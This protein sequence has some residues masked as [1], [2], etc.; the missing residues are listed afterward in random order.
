MDDNV[1]VLPKLGNRFAKQSK[2]KLVNDDNVDPDVKRVL[3]VS[4]P[5]DLDVIGLQHEPTKE[6][7]QS[8]KTSKDSKDTKN[9]KGTTSSMWSWVIIVLAFIVV[10]LVIA[11]A[12]YILKG[13][14]EN[15]KPQPIP[16]NVLEPMSQS[17]KGQ[18][19][20]QMPN[21]MHNQM[22]NQMPNQ[23]HN[24]MPNQ[25][26]NCPMNRPQTEQLP[27]QTKSMH[28]SQHKQPS[29]SELEET[30]KKLESI[31]ETNDEP[32]ISNTKKNLLKPR[33]IKPVKSTE[34][35]S[36][37]TDYDDSSENA[38]LDNK[39]SKKF[40]DNLQKNLDL[41]KADSDTEECR[42]EQD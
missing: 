25:M 22:P 9:N 6:E 24:Q 27:I 3:N 38:E 40:Y 29:K 16:P 18:R 7:L 34:I 33:N 41:D 28:S 12:W 14:T 20:T 31:K 1:T 21:Q 5:D 15:V 8:E 32:T 26:A 23:M 4:N 39:L 30:L 10:V 19:P 2:T 37:N 35:K 42:D 17:Y 13:N 36:N 11:I